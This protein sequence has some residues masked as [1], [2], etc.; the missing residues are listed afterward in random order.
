MGMNR[1]KLIKYTEAI[2]ATTLN[3]IVVTGLIFTRYDRFFWLFIFLLAAFSAYGVVC[4]LAGT[5]VAGPSEQ[6]NYLDTVCNCDDCKNARLQCC[7]PP[8]VQGM[9]KSGI[10]NI[11]IGVPS[12]RDYVISNPWFDCY[13]GLTSMLLRVRLHE[14]LS[15]GSNDGS[16]NNNDGLPEEIEAHFASIAD[17][18]WN[19][20]TEQERDKADELS[21]RIKDYY[22]SLAKQ[23]ELDNT[24]HSKAQDNEKQS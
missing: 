24:R 6:N 23:M 19:K 15:S 7:H 2:F 20:M 18:Y 12:M 13:M 3:I 5:I 11:P 9:V 10:G 14:R 16:D 21:V 17:L 4:I 8:S 22:D 1:Q